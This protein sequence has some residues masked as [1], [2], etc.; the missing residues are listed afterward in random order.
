MLRD[1]SSI[2]NRELRNRDG[3]IVTLD[4]CG[5]FSCSDRNLLKGKIVV[6]RRRVYIIHDDSAFRDHSKKVTNENGQ[7]VIELVD[8]KDPADDLV[9]D[10]ISRNE[11]LRVIESKKEVEVTDS[12][13]KDRLHKL[14][15][16][17]KMSTGTSKIKD[18]FKGIG[19]KEPQKSFI[20]AGLMSSDGEY[21]EEVREMAI[22]QLI[23]ERIETED[24]QEK[25]TNYAESLIGKR[26]CQGCK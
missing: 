21:S 3:E 24:F 8:R 19:L 11:N 2:T 26:D 23:S 20:K 10:P 1:Y 6:I 5:N 4:I 18:F 7:Y 13:V 9:R 25:L 14:V 16:P 12:D 22:D 17:E 15:N